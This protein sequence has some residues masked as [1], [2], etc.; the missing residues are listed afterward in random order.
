M[1]SIMLDDASLDNDL[2]RWFAEPLVPIVNG[3]IKLDV[4]QW[5]RD[6]RHR[7]PVLSHLAFDLLATPTSSSACE[8]QF[9]LAGHVLDVERWY[10]QVDF[11]EAHR[12]L[13]NWFKM[14]LVSKITMRA[15]VQPEGDKDSELTSEP[16]DIHS[17]QQ[18]IVGD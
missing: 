14:D 11:A 15:V 4:I 5:W 10:T 1:A 7:Y 17:P 6:N 13:K 9:S 16:L 2:A 8:R 3:K 18:T 12:L